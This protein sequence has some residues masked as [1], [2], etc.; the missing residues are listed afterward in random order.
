[1]DL[2]HEEVPRTREDGYPNG[3]G[4]LDGGPL[5]AVNRPPQA[6]FGT[7]RESVNIL[8]VRHESVNPQ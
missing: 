2:A 7:S 5:R 6:V 4:R 1:M 8:M 3:R